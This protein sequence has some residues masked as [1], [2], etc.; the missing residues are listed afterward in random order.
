MKNK[1]VHIYDRLIEGYLFTVK[2]HYQ[3]TPA[4]H[5]Q[6]QETDFEIMEVWYKGTEITEIYDDYFSEV[7]ENDVFEYATDNN[8]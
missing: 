5:D 7:L 4:T 8:L 1:N 6:P 2:F 3:H